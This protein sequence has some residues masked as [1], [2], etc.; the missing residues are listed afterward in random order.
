EGHQTTVPLNDGPIFVASLLP[1][2]GTLAWAR[3]AG[4][5]V[6]GQAYGV[7]TDS[8]GATVAVT[9][10]VNGPA[11]FG[12]GMRGAV[13]VDPARGRAFVALWDDL[14]EF[15]WA[16]GLGGSMGEGDAIAFDP[17]GRVAVTGTFEDL[18]G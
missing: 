2:D 18:W 4:G 5:G 11:I 6:P 17:A 12:A 10:Y 8:E 7:A 1:E 3:F 13:T 16:V 15:G 14:G 9:G